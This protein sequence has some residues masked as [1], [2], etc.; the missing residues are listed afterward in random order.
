MSACLRSELAKLSE[1]A[2]Q[3]RGSRAENVLLQCPS[4]GLEKKMNLELSVNARRVVT[5]S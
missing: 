2:G 5:A 1:A 4:C 3:P